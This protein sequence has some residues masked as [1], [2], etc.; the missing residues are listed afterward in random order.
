MARNIDA[1]LCW[2]DALDFCKIYIS[3]HQR[4][5]W[6]STYCFFSNPW[7]IEIGSTQQYILPLGFQNI[8]S[9]TIDMHLTFNLHYVWFYVV[10]CDWKHYLHLIYIFT[11]NLSFCA[12]YFFTCGILSNPDEKLVLTSMTLL[13]LWSLPWQGKLLTVTTTALIIS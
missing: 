4:V 8:W 13:Y 7:I 1:N 3:E 2:A 5:P 11:K 12:C 10:L 6:S 9:P